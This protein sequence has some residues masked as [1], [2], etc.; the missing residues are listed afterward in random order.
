MSEKVYDVGQK[1]NIGYYGGFRHQTLIKA[2][3]EVTKVSGDWIWINVQLPSG[4]YKQMF[5]Y[6]YQ[7]K[8]MEENFLLSEK[9]KPE[10]EGLE[11]MKRAVNA[12]EL[13]TKEAYEFEC[14][15]SK[16]YADLVSCDEWGCASVWLGDAG[17]EYNFCKDGEDCSA[18]YK[19]EMNPETGCMETD[20]DEFIH[21]EIDFDDPE[22]EAALENAMCEAL[23]TFLGNEANK[24]IEKEREPER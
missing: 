19:T 4:G 23:V 7:L 2:Q 16:E 20:Y 13:K 10:K 3:A 5:G 11:E 24:E 15:I 17:A 22:W 9:N 18:I 14:N 6:D 12:N 21:Y 1:L 8:A